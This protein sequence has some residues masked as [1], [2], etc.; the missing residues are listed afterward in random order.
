[1][2]RVI[3]L[4]E[5]NPYDEELTLMALE[6]NHFLNEIVVARDGE[7][8]LDFLFGS[9]PGS[10]AERNLLPTIILL[11]LQLPKV[12]GLDVLRKIRAES[13][14]RSLPVV[15]LTSSQEDKDLLESY[16]LGCNS[17]VRKPVDFAKF[18]EAAQQLGLYWLLLNECPPDAI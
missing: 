12:S 15:I 1:M 6:K 7:E 14:T 2:N 18:V 13:L 17:F 10:A 11:D 9:G 4:I 16:S 8:A 5:D 3:L